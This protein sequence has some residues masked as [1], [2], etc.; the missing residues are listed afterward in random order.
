MKFAGNGETKKEDLHRIHR[1]DQFHKWQPI[2]Y[3]FVYV[4][5]RPT[6]FVLKEH[7]SCTLSVL[8]RL[9]GLISTKYNR[10]FFLATIYAIGQ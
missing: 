2:N 5:I 7:F 4:L 8:M 3:S 9:V 1:I 10:I 6:S